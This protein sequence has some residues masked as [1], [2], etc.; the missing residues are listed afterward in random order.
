MTFRPL[1]FSL[2]TGLVLAALCA[3]LPVRQGHAQ[4]VGA[5]TLVIPRGTSTLITTPSPIQ[6]VSVGDPEIA[7][8]ITV[9]PREVLVNAR[10]LG[11]TSLIVWLA[12]GTRRLYNLEVTVDAP[13]LERQLRTLF[14]NQ[15]ISVTASGN[16]LII[17]GRVSDA[18]IARRA[19]EI[20]RGTGATVIENLNIPP[21]RQILLQVRFAEVTR[22]AATQLGADYLTG[23]TDVPI[24][25]GIEE[26]DRVIETLSDGLMRIFLFED[27][28][29]FSAVIQA[30]KRRGMFRSLAEPNLLAI[31]G[32]EASFLAG[33]EIPIPVPQTGQGN[34]TITIVFKEFGIRLRFTPRVT[35]AG[36]VRLEV[37]PEVSALDYANAIQFS[38]FLIPALRTRRA[39]TEIEL[40]PGQTFAIAGLMDNTIQDNRGR[41]PF[42]GDLPILGPLFR[43]KDITQNRTELLVLVTPQVVEPSETA[44][45]VPTGEPESWRWERSLRGQS[46]PPAT[47]PTQP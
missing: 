34:N 44:P 11:S 39:E 29:Q 27:N 25:G 10:A 24:V 14:P 8:P 7:D 47:P 38:G 31:E 40:R 41:I 37:A 28:I 3:L 32:R 36:N 2:L 6:R 43:S 15:P 35:I 9:S 17:S 30:L 20:A 46:T 45:P 22:S 12:D 13:A 19:L 26:G 42:L 4:V 18:G 1:R 23:E 5:E 33:G 16:V 21:A